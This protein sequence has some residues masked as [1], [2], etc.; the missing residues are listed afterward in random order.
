MPS[1]L[2]SYDTSDFTAIDFSIDIAKYYSVTSAILLSFIP[3]IRFSDI[4]ALITTNLLPKHQ[5]IYTSDTSTIE[6]T[7]TSTN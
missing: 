7:I 3:A 2:Y 5:P 4:D 6:S 1:K